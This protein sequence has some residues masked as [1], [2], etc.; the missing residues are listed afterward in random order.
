MVQTIRLDAEHGL[1]FT[2]RPGTLTADLS[3][4][5]TQLAATLE[6]QARIPGSVESLTRGHWKFRARSISTKC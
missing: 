3:V 1:D 6:E 4:V 5:S 2:S